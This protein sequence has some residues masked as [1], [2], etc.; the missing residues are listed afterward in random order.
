MNLILVLIITGIY[1]LHALREIWM[2]VYMINTSDPV[3]DYCIL[4]AQADVMF[5]F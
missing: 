3:S 1:C 2:L 5:I 4:F